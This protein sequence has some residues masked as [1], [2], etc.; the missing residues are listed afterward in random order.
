[1]SDFSG[2][3]PS[4]GRMP[5]GIADAYCEP[6]PLTTDLQP[7]D[8]AFQHLRGMA[9]I[10]RI[11]HL[12]NEIQLPASALGDPGFAAREKKETRSAWWVPS[13]AMASTSAPSGCCP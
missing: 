11:V 7:Q 12:R 2:L 8:V 1:M 3:E 5:A 13:C 4:F 9:G 6:P 10:A